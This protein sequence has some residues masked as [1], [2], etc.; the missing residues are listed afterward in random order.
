MWPSLCLGGTQTTGLASQ[1]QRYPEP[2]VLPAGVPVQFGACTS[3][4]PLDQS[5]R[6]VLLGY[7]R[8]TAGARGR[9]LLQG[10][11]SRVTGAADGNPMRNPNYEGQER[12]GAVVADRATL[13]A[14][15]WSAGR[16]WRWRARSLRGPPSRPVFA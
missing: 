11:G 4:L 9:P 16:S 8:R 2:E 3:G 5:I 7:M 10:D 1:E 15:S 14:A 13:P 12:G 6:G